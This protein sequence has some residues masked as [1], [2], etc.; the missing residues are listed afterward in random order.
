MLQLHSVVVRV[1]LYVASQVGLE[2]CNHPWGAHGMSGYGRSGPPTS[3][4][5][6]GQSAAGYSNTA[7]TSSNANAA[8]AIFTTP[9]NE[10]AW[11]TA[12]HGSTASPVKAIRC[13]S[14]QPVH[15]GLF[16]SRCRLLSS[17]HRSMVGSTRDSIQGS[18]TLVSNIL[19]SMLASILANILASTQASSILGNTLANIQFS[20]PVSILSRILGNTPVSIQDNIQVHI[21]A[22]TLVSSSHILASHTQDST[23]AS[24]TPLRPKASILASTLLSI[25]CPIQHRI[26]LNTLHSIPARRS[27]HN[28]H[29]SSSNSIPHHH[30]FP[31]HPVAQ[32]RHSNRA[33]HLLPSSIIRHMA[34]KVH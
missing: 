23:L 1:G 26:Q 5:Q 24:H 7:T 32:V 21:L 15:R 10:P 20:T 22:N 11:S 13:L 34:A 9:C 33:P 30:Q 31:H 2:L 4:L 18:S 27:S 16:N 3:I 29:L 28:S 8:P 12:T 17:I 19:D 14:I 6:H 25:Q